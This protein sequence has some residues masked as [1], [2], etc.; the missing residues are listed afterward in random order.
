M[1]PGLLQKQCK[2]QFSG[3]LGSSESVLLVTFYQNVK[4]STD[5]VNMGP[6]NSY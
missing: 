3:A 2:S 5:N 4:I 1:T 6:Y